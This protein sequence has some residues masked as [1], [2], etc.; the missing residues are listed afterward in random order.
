[1]GNTR[2]WYFLRDAIR[3]L[4]SAGALKTCELQTAFFS[5]KARIAGEEVEKKVASY[6]SAR[7]FGSTRVRE[8]LNAITRLEKS[9]EGSKERQ[10]EIRQTQQFI[11]AKRALCNLVTCGLNALKALYEMEESVSSHKALEEI[12][13]AIFRK[14]I[15]EILHVSTRVPSSHYWQEVQDI[16]DG[17]EEVL[18]RPRPEHWSKTTPKRNETIAG[19]NLRKD[20]NKL[21]ASDE[22]TFKR[23]FSMLGPDLYARFEDEGDQIALLKE[24]ME[25]QQNLPPM[26]KVTL[27]LAFLCQD[28]FVAIRTVAERASEPTP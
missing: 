5:V 11:E 21:F 7:E 9:V 24:V 19:T 10:P 16:L 13:Q 12:H 2:H 27:D 17:V 20:T 18:R 15:E 6:D 26:I 23:W 8:A 14:N 28:Q 4:N 1:L 3:R 25:R 22:A